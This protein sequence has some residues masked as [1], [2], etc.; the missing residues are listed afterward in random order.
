MI[1][2][3][4]RFLLPSGTSLDAAKSLF[5]Q[6]APNYEGLPGLVRKYYLYDEGGDGQPSGGGVYLWESRAAAEAVYTD[7]WKNTIAERYGTA[8]EISY[9][10]SP[11]IIDNS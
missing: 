6:S 4:V 10:E 2:A 11:V 1:T 7:G 3:I 8:P 5:E 9:F